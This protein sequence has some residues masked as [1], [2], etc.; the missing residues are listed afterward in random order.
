MAHRRAARRADRARA[1]FEDWYRQRLALLLRP[2]RRR[3]WCPSRSSCPRGDQLASALVRGLLDGPGTRTRRVSRTFFPPG[4][5]PTACRCRSPTAGI[6]EVDAR[7]ATRPRSTEET[8]ELMLAQLAWTLRQDPRDPRLPS[9]PSAASRSRCRAGRPRSASTSAAAYDPDGVQ[10]EPR[11]VRRS[12]TACS[13]RGAAR[14]RRPRSTGPL[15]QADLGCATIG[16]QPRGLTGSPAVS[17]D[18]T[19]AAASPRSTAPRQPGRDGRQRGHRPAARRPGTSP[20]GCGCVDRTGGG[21]AACSLVVDGRAA[22]RSTCPGITGATVTHV[23][24]LARRHAGSSRSSRGRDGR[25]RR[26][27]AGSCTT[28]PGGCSSCDPGP[29]LAVA[30]E[31]SRAD[32]RHRLALADHRRRCCTDIT[33]DLSQV[34]TVSVDGVAR[35]RSTTGSPRSA[36]GTRALVVAPRVEGERPVRRA[37]DAASST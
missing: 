1:W 23:P 27:S 21:A 5:R 29:E 16:G 25:P 2:D 35:A 9:S 8:A 14:R 19:G 32:P 37:P 20:T 15:G 26:A 36:G 33:D 22:R 7:T 28:T 17:G 3:S 12:A 4:T 30:D 31:G 6:A 18:G 24:G 34:R 11:A 13:C 10:S